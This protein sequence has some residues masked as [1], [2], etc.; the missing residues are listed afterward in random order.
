MLESK[1]DNEEDSRKNHR[2]DH[3]ENCRTLQLLPG[4]PGGLFGQFNERLF[5]IVN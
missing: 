1:V 5:E 2:G 4:R 3:D